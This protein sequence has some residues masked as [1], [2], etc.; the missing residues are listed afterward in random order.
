MPTGSGNGEGTGKGVYKEE[1][2]NA[3]A[4]TQPTSTWSLRCCGKCNTLAGKTAWGC[5]AVP[6]GSV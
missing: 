3:G 5:V 6:A 2:T 4:E 1:L